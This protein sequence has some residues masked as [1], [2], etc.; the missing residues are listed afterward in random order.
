MPVGGGEEEQAIIPEH[1]LTWSTTLQPTKQGMYYFEW[2]RSASAPAVSFFDFAEKK[3]SV[4]FHMKQGGARDSTY[5][6]SPDGKF[7]L[8]SRVD[9]SQTNLEVLENFH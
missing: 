7:I 5:S 2:E 1:D 8:Y 4:V 9:R 3:S 6:V